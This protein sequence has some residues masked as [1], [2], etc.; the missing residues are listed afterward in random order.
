MEARD[1]AQSRAEHAAERAA[2]HESRGQNDA[3]LAHAA[4][5]FAAGF[6]CAAIHEVREEAAREDGRGERER[7]INAECE[8]HRRLA[9]HFK[10]YRN[11]RAHTEQ[12]I[13]D[14]LV[15][16]K[17]DDQRLHDGGLGRGENGARVAGSGFSELEG[18]GQEHNGEPGSSG[19]GQDAKE[20]GLLL[21]GWSVAEP[22]AGFEVGHELA[23]DAQRGAH[24]AGNGHDEEHARGSGE[25]EAQQH[26]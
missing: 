11:E 21:R 17:S 9:E 25:A 16:H 12:K 19:G 3:A 4:A 1:K 26:H 14:R 13:S 8:N 22:V 18:V 23:G 5:G 20:F 2:G 15:A 7:Q 24:H 6:L 10:N